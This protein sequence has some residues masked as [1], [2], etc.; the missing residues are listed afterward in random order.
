MALPVVKV[1]GARDMQANLT[2]VVRGEVRVDPA[3]YRARPGDNMDDACVAFDYAQ[4]ALGLPTRAPAEELLRDGLERVKNRRMGRNEAFSWEY[5][6]LSLQA[7][8]IQRAAAAALAAKDPRWQAVADGQRD[9]L[10][11]L[12]GWYALGACWG[13][14]RDILLEQNKPGAGVKVCLGPHI[15]AYCGARY[16]VAIGKRSWVYDGSWAHVHIAPVALSIYGYGETRNCKADLY[17][18]SAREACK[19]RGW[20]VEL[21]TEGEQARLRQ[22]ADND[23]EALRWILANVIRDYI[24]AEPIHILRTT[25]GVSWTMLEA[26]DSST[27]TGY[28][29]TWRDDGRVWFAGT[30][31]GGRGGRGEAT[32][33]GFAEVNVAARTGFCQNSVGSRVDFDLVYGEKVF[34][35]VNRPGIGVFE[36]RPAGETSPEPPLLPR[37]VKP[38]KQ[39]WWEKFLAWLSDVF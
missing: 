38:E 11:A 8:V 20:P 25:K 17:P 29:C 28:H 27:S 33:P 4:L 32:F 21:F 7:R 16:C 3:S 1:E 15:Q 19:A 34:E 35:V 30:D 13:P 12:I 6:D 14:G 31:S 9:Y 24:P 18:D 5:G 26:S 23:V 37:V 2:R 10:R 36:Q 22:A 39:S